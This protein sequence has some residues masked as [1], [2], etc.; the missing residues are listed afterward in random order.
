M[1]VILQKS[2]LETFGPIVPPSPLFREVHEARLHIL[3]PTWISDPGCRALTIHPSVVLEAS[4]VAFL[5]P[6]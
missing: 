4:M 6:V 2:P 3:L 1:I 5:D